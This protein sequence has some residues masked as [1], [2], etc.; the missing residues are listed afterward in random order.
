M[1][2][3]ESGLLQI[4]G[5]GDSVQIDT[6]KLAGEGVADPSQRCIVDIVGETPIK[7]THVPSDD[8]LER[9]EAEIPACPL[10]FDVLSGAVL[11]P[12]QITAC[13]FKAADCQ[14]SPG[15][16]WG[17]AAATLQPEAEAI[18]KRRFQGDNTI[19]K[20]LKALSERA[21]DHPDA[22][23]LLED[24]KAFPGQRDDACR[25]YQKEATL[26]FCAASLTEARAILL[27]T[28]LAALGE[29][30]KAA[31]KDEKPEKEKE[32][33]AEADRSLTGAGAGR[34]RRAKLALAASP[35]GGADLMPTD[36][37]PRSAPEPRLAATVLLVRD[38]ADGLEVFMVV[39]HR[40]I[41]FA[42]GALVFPGGSVDPDD[43]ALAS[44]LDRS[45]LPF[46]ADERLCALRIAAVR[47]TFEEC[48]VLLARPRGS[49]AFVE[50]ARVAEL[51]RK[52]P[53][54]SFAELMESEALEPAID[55]LT[56]FAHWITPPILPKRFDT[57]FFIASA[58]ADQL[59]AH[60]GAES[61]DFGLAQSGARPDP[62]GGRALHHA[63]S[64]PAQS[65]NA[66]A[67][68]RH[69]FRAGGGARTQNRHRSSGR[70]EARRRQGLHPQHPA[71]RGL[72]RGDFLGLTRSVS[73]GDGSGG[74][75]RQAMRR[76]RRPEAR[77]GRRSPRRASSTAPRPPRSI[78]SA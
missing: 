46:G 36:A 4:S 40:Q 17:P 77:R 69:G 18:A 8:G 66:R 48:G 27:Q 5:S 23:N 32:G 52:A 38:G 11:V 60:D 21:G 55:L 1:L 24:Q 20:A 63:V 68:E 51:G 47:E 19:S 34:R 41:E 9:Y 13:V 25:A 50:G 72:W 43:L 73:P 44:Q 74:R 65:R 42:S 33:G 28:R 30:S 10:A 59:A 16:L 62:R 56:P 12:S 70:E 22:A 61:V 75:F 29:P 31:A 7:A 6:L 26:G 78:L 57:H 67:R 15:G 3:G 45:G 2:N 37:N 64:D 53:G 76:R 49:R 71:R 14:T 54:M 39:R 35:Q 58:P